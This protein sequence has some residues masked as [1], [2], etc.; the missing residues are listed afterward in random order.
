LPP[1]LSPT[2]EQSDCLASHK[3]MPGK[4]Q[5][6]PTIWPEL[7]QTFL[8]VLYHCTK[9]SHRNGGKGIYG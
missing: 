3:T 8:R 1:V 9:G 4:F 6:V 5:P 2:R 7:I